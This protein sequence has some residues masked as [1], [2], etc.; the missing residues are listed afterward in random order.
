M[1]FPNKSLWT[2]WQHRGEN[3]FPGG[4]C[5]LCALY[6]CAVINS[7]VSVVTVLSLVRCDSIDKLKTQLPKMEQEL[8][9]HGKFKDFYQ[10]T[11]NFAKNPG[12]KG[13]GEY[14][15]LALQ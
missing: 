9:D 1:N 4:S 8:K 14:L 5:G 10:F 3:I 2:G 13:L 12:Q 15:V 6:L 7:T 11:F